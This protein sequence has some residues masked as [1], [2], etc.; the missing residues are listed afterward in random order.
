MANEA[1][2]QIPRFIFFFYGLLKEGERVRERWM[3]KSTGYKRGFLLFLLLFWLSFKR[4][5]QQVSDNKTLI[6]ISKCDNYSDVFLISSEI[7][8]ENINNKNI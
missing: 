4:R 1:T 5:Q 8:R 7:F 6:F 3:I 2:T